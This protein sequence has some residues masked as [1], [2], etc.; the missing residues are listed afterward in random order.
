MLTRAVALLRATAEPVTFAD[1][2][3]GLGCAEQTGGSRDHVVMNG[4][5]RRERQRLQRVLARAEQQGIVQRDGDR[6]Q[7]RSLDEA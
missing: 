1:L 4:S 6:V 7:L 3:R 5:A 2:C